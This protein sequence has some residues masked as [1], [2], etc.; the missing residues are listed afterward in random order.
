MVKILA[1]LTDNPNAPNKNG[2]TPI[3]E[4][5]EKGYTEIVK[6]LAPLTDNPNAPENNGTTPIHI[7]ALH[8]HTEIVKILIPLTDNPI[9]WATRYGHSTKFLLSRPL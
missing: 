5:A 7:A 8:G 3:H 2:R 1:S 6:I 4:A 9:H